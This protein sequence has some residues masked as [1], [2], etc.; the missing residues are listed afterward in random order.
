MLTN[1]PTYYERRVYV[2]I[3]FHRDITVSEASQV[4]KSLGCYLKQDLRGNVVITPRA[5]ASHP[6]NEYSTNIVP[7]HPVEPD[8][9]A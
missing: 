9:A 2:M 4:A 1:T 7:L 3:Y 6:R 8:A 5:S